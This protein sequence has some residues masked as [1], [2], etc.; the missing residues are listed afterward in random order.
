MTRF[1]ELS[2]SSPEKSSRPDQRNLRSE[3]L[4]KETATV[5][6]I[7]NLYSD[8]PDPGVHAATDWLLLRYGLNGERVRLDQ[9]MV[10]R[11]PQGDR[12]WYVNRQGHTMVWIPG[13]A[14]FIMGQPASESKHA[15]ESQR[16]HVRI[17]R[18]YCIAS[19]ETS[20]SQFNRFL[21]DNPP[22]IAR[23]SRPNPATGDIPQADVS[24]YEAVAYCNWLSAGEGLPE[25][26]WCYEPNANGSY[27]PGMQIAADYA[28][29]RGYRL[30]TEAEWEYACRAKPTA[31]TFSAITST[32]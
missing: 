3:A 32:T 5:P 11:E 8:D 23:V 25:E 22:D 15:E 27:G 30:P 16:R 18:S 19:K 7:L 12:Q 9:R 20:V 21:A 31:A 28:N 24:W 1:V 29:R 13:P 26:E 6:T 10:G 17:R 2:C 14:Q 4:R